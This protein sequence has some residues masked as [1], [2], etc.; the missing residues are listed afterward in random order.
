VNIERI[1]I[2]AR[3]F[4]VTQVAFTCG[5][6]SVPLYCKENRKV[7]HLEHIKQRSVVRVFTPRENTLLMPEE[8]QASP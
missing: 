4:V 8:A 1:H 2:A 6:L 3:F 7:L 5:K